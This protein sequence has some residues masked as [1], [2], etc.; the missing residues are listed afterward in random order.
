MT[1]IKTT[2]MYAYIVMVIVAGNRHGHSSSNLNEAVCISHNTWEMYAFHITLGE[3]YASKYSLSSYGQIVG[4][5]A[6]FKV[7]MTTSLGEGKFFIRNLLN[8]IWKTDH[9]ARVGVMIN[10]YILVV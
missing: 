10:I 1:I 2:S 4:Q 6:L 3:M 7:G 8:A 9:R 5:S